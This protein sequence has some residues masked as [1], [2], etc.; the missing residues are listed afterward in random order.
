VIVGLPVDLKLNVQVPV[1][2][3]SVMVHPEGPVTLTLPVG[4]FPVPEL[5][6]LTVTN[7]G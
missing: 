3:T 5:T 4:G 7:V 1:P 2:F 6:T